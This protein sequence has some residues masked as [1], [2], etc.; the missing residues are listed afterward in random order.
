MPRGG[1]RPGSGAKP[2]VKRAMTELA[3]A[4]AKMTGI[5]PHEWLL[6]VMRGEPIRQAR[7]R[8]IL[9]KQ[10][11]AIGQ[12]VEMYDHYPDIAMRADAA[13][14]AAPYYAPRLATQVVTIRGR[15]DL[16]NSMTDSELEKQIKALEITPSMMAHR[17][18]DNRK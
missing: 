18:G 8:T 6:Q 7:V 11:E 2:G 13:K 9:N 1:P 10:G 5:L 12:E 4:E 16:L 15:E 3:K 17:L 14:A